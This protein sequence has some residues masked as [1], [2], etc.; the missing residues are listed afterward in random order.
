MKR[1]IVLALF[2]GFWSFN[3]SAQSNC[4]QYYPLVEGAS[5]T[6]TNYN[7]RGK[8]DGSIAFKV[9]SVENK[10]TKTNA[11]MKMSLLN[12]KG[13]ETNNM[14]YGFTCEGDVVKIDYKSLMPTKML[15]EI[16]AKGQVKM[17]GTDIELPNNLEVGQELADA[18]VNISIDMGVAAMDFNVET[19]DRKIEKREKITTPAGTFDC[20][21]LS[22]N[23]VMTM[24]M[25]GDQNSI[26][27]TWI[28]EGIGMVK[29]ISYAK[30][31]EEKPMLTSELT[32][33]KK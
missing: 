33:Y 19:L 27:K 17:S 23:H 14:E 16:G 21:V 9:V 31:D 4:S 13:K 20:L 25:G 22:E 24:P 32:A 30:N 28:A 3:T 11:K 29:Q 5:F 1:L 15:N 12:K 7:A 6:Y 18:R 8:S 2:F 26:S 10:G